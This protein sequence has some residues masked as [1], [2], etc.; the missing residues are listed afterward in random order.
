MK[1]LILKVFL[2]L[3]SNSAFAA[4]YIC[5]GAAGEPV[6]EIIDVNGSPQF[7]YLVNESVRF[8]VMM[9]VGSVQP[10]TKRPIGFDAGQ[11]FTFRKDEEVHLYGKILSHG[12]LFD[13]FVLGKQGFVQRTL[14]DYECSAKASR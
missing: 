1:V 11:T 7:R 6:V 4:D 12:A 9:D 3:V 14:V 2:L 8:S 5:Q 10:I 13:V